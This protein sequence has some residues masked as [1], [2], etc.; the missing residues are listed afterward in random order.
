VH[1]AVLGL[2]VLHLT[3]EF[4]PLCLGGLGPAVEGVATASARAGAEVAVLLVDQ[5]SPTLRDSDEG[6]PPGAL[7]G[8]YGDVG[9]AYGMSK[10]PR[11]IPSILANPPHLERLACRSSGVELFR[12]T[13]SQ[14]T[15]DI[16]RFVRA[17]KP[18]L[19]HLH[20][21]WL[22][23]IA[24]AARPAAGLPMVYTA[25]SVARAEFELGGDLAEW[26]ANG[27]EQ[28]A[29]VAAAARIVAVSR[30]DADMLA[31]FHPD[32]ARRIRVVKHGA[33]RSLGHR[34][35]RDRPTSD[36]PI[37]LFAGR[38]IERKGVR[39]LLRA[40]PLIKQRVPDVRLVLAG[41]EPGRTPA[42]LA[43]TWMPSSN[44]PTSAVRFTGW[45]GRDAL[46]RWYRRATVLAVPS[47]YEPFGLVVLEAMA[48]GLP[49]VAAAGG[50]SEII[51]HEQTGLLVPSRDPE[52]LAAAIIRL[53]ADPD[54]RAV[55]ADAASDD[56]R[57]RWR[58]STSARLMETVYTEAISAS[59]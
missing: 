31:A 6:G 43:Q 59:C 39:D 48:A 20:V 47:R 45:L 41:G 11:A 15:G 29:A 1:T 37:V 38:L 51:D 5:G 34:P 27:I 26:L 40:L 49:V 10:Q 4:P 36:P 19:Q 8:Y 54:L 32:A 53:V 30:T 44:G 3:S 35:H 33:P 18:S 22:W 16:S 42:E 56:V 2:R 52:T 58:W 21:P 57:V 9:S 28:Q 50:P 23:P 12:V 13:E 7:R 46:G 17:W 55:L 14:A 24:R 25:H